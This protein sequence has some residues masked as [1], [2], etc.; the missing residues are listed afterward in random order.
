M[1]DNKQVVVAL[2][3]FA[4]ENGA[5]KARKPF[6]AQ[7][8]SNGDAALQTTILRVNAKHKASVHDPRRVLAGTLT[9]ALT[10]GL[11]GLVAGTNKVESAIVWALLG[12]LCGGVYAYTSE[13]RLTKSEL[14]RIGRHL[15]PGSSAL[16]TYAEAGDP[17][18]LLAAAGAYAP[19]TASL[20]T[21]DADMVARVFAGTTAPVEVSHSSHGVTPAPDEVSLLSMI[22]SRYPD[23][24]AAVQ[25]AAQVAKRKGANG[26]TPEIELVIE[27]DG[28]GHRHVIDPTSGTAAWARS[29][30]VS[31][32]LF[33][34]VWGA[35]VGALGGGGILG[36][37][38]DG[39][40]TGV[41][42]AVFG[43]LAGALYGLW[44][45]R[46]ISAR[47]LK[48]IGPMLAPGT[49]TVLAWAEGALHDGDLEALSQ[50]GAQRLVL[51]FNPVDHG[52][53][54]EAA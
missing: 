54:L 32:G 24:K 43:L 42:W 47:R 38:K 12:A 20:A 4:D 14:A 26:H 45:G 17:E 39:L 1:S 36:F 10:W 25:V 5:A 30:T 40:V 8:Q 37:L 13:H 52:A 48:G 18:R 50:P 15:A 11:F 19:S 2:F 28:S 27:T 49:S 23:P 44:A 16:L 41:G 3:C 46:S 53:V 31:W 34:L 51:L 7:L 9:A 35:I 21:I 22:V 6:E 33:G 29:D